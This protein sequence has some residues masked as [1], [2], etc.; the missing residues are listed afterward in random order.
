VAAEAPPRRRSRLWL[1]AQITFVALA[2]VYVAITLRG[3][4]TQLGAA[5][6]DLRPRWSL[7]VLSSLVVFASYFVLIQTWRS[8]LRAW[9][10]ELSLADATT[11][12]FVSNLGKY[13]PG[14][15]WQITAMA[16][17]AQSRGVST[18]AAAGSSLIVNLVNVITGFLVV[19]ATGIGV[20]GIRG[21]RAPI[22]AAV[23]TGILILGAA[24]LPVLMPLVAR[25][26]RR[27]LKRDIDIARI[28]ARALWL[29]AIG[30]ATAWVLY[31]IAFRLLAAAVMPQASTGSVWSYVAVFT[32]SYLVGYLVLA[33]PG[34]IL[35]R[36]SFLASGMEL[37]GL[38]TY[39]IGWVL[40]A[41]SRL[42]LTVLELVPGFL[43][44]AY[45]GLR[46]RPRH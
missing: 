28:P 11:I 23:L 14:K 32:S 42:W 5:V 44:L 16:A 31:G 10:T 43:L 38:S 26:V 45:T 19:F 15:V 20:L 22:T 2:V 46:R 40:A 3:Q 33:A 39:A 30:T 24:L 7:V 9:G 18:V 4:W 6:R 27:V 8:M 21:A 12:W 36:E 25:I 41:A 34:G 17:M 29:A 13:I 1:V 35:V 37:L